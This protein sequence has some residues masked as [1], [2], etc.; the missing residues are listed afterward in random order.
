M[1]GP[2]TAVPAEYNGR[3]ATA[4]DVANATY[5]SLL[6]EGQ[7]Y[8]A[9]GTLTVHDANVDT[10]ST[11]GFKISGTTVTLADATFG[12]AVTSV[13]GAFV[14]STGVLT[15]TR[16]GGQATDTIAAT[17]NYAKAVSTATLAN[18]YYD[19]GDNIR[20]WYEVSANTA[21]AGIL[22]CTDYGV[23]QFLAAGNA[24]VAPV[25]STFGRSAPS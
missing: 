19:A 18:T 17:V 2:L 15:L 6:T 10:D 9:F 21:S 24:I 12:G 13:A 7:Y 11:V 22:L 16:T 20:G 25:V 1:S 3:R 4:A 14:C 8:T 23:F 5:G